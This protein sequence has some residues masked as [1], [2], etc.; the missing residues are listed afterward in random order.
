M[1][2]NRQWSE[3]QWERIY[4]RGGFEGCEEWIYKV[5]QGEEEKG[6][7]T[8]TVRVERKDVV[9][10]M[11]EEGELEEVE[12]RL[13]VR[14]ATPSPYEEDGIPLFVD[15]TWSDLL[16]EEDADKI[17]QEIL[18]AICEE[19]LKNEKISEK[20]NETVK[21]ASKESTKVS[22]HWLLSLPF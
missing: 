3:Q 17:E 4:L 15:T 6:V 21:M 9:E 18:R 14:F 16:A 1:P 8:W 20:D 7:W 11:R 19:S 22:P 13:S 5:K 2:T 10:E 12:R